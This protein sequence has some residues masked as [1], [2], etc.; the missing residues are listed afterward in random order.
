MNNIAPIPVAQFESRVRNAPVFA[1]TT[2]TELM[3]TVFPPIG[4]IVEGYVAEGL[5]VLA[6]RQKLGKTWLA[7]D[8]AIAVACGGM[9][10]G[11]IECSAG[12]VLYVDL[13]NG[14]RRMQSR[15][16]TL[17]PD[18]GQL[19]DLSRLEWVNDAPDLNKGF[20]EALD[21]WRRSVPNPRL[22]IVDVLQ[23]I[24]PAGK[25]FQNAYESD[26]ETMEGLQRWATEHRVAVVC[27]HHTRKG[28]ADDPLEALSG[29]NGLSAC[30]DTT[31]VLDRDGNGTTLYVR[32]R[33]VEERESALTFTCGHWTLAGSAVEVR[34]SAE[35]NA[36]LAALG[37]A[38]EPLSPSEIAD[39]TGMKAGNVRKLLLGMVKAGEVTKVERGRY[40][41]TGAKPR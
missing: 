6:G 32:G 9:A 13:E 1:R 14:H 33:D 19:P 5:S 4:W 25:A 15:I 26:Y 12:D 22:V 16:R 34:R 21:T 7:L 17:F 28:G 29:S 10:M 3:A 38:T 23:R 31:L 20:V 27:L 8:W 40:S 24:K 30:A 2:T 41:L 36:I 11:S 39:V 35:R 37:D 18:D